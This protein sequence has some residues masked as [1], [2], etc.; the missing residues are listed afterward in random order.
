[1]IEFVMIKPK[2]EINDQYFTALIDTIK[3]K[4]PDTSVY[5]SN[6]DRRKFKIS[7]ENTLLYFGELWVQTYQGEVHLFFK[8]QPQAKDKTFDST[9][10]DMKFL[11]KD[12]LLK[13]W[14]ECIWLIDEQSDLLAAELYLKNT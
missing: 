2:V 8:L 14:E 6:L 13:N 10:H 11:F 4:Y 7:G 1:M 12:I 3:E 9:L 5:E